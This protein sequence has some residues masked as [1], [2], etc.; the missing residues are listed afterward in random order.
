MKIVR[1]A[2]LGAAAY[3]VKKWLEENPDAKRQVMGAAGTAKEQ[4]RHAADTVKAEVDAR[5]HKNGE[6]IGDDA[7]GGVPTGS[8]AGPAEQVGPAGMSADGGPGLGAPTTP[9]DPAR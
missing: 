5:R 7:F 1:L 8:M 9:V 6:P 2:V 4:A 3:G